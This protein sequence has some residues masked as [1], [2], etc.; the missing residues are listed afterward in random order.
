MHVILTGA[1]GLVGSGVLDAMIK[2]KDISKISILSRR[3]VPMVDDAKDPRINVIIHKN[4]EQYDSELIEKLKGAHGCVWALGISQTQVGAEEYVKITKTYAV[5]AAKA[6]RGLAS[7]TEPFNF[8]YVSGLGATTQPGRFAAI[9]ARVKGETELALAVLRKEN[10][11]FHTSS[12]RPAFVDAASHQAIKPYLPNK[13]LVNKFLEPLLS[14]LVRLGIKSIHSPTDALGKVLTEMAM[15]RHKDQF[16][17]GNGIQ[18]IG[19]FP[20]LENSALRRLVGL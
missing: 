18:K 8:V 4:F 9:F 7:E 14:P 12:A 13:P 10:P 19:D 11:N 6:F 5:E 3:P 17:A 15:G 1:T 16:V 2:T 20:I